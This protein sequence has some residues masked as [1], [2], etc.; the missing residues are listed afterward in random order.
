MLTAMNSTTPPPQPVQVSQLVWPT[1]PVTTNSKITPL[2]KFAIVFCAAI[3]VGTAGLYGFIAVALSKHFEV[4]KCYI[5]SDSGKVTKNPVPCTASAPPNR[6]MVRITKK[7]DYQAQQTPLLFPGIGDTSAVLTCDPE[8]IRLELEAQ[9]TGTPLDVRNR[10]G[11]LV[12]R[13]EEKAYCFEPV[14]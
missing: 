5:M 14:R 2:G 10:P 12:D 8:R 9:S 4:G 6:R 13:R 3:V 11:A 7:F 1:T